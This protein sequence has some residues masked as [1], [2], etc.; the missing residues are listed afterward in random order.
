MEEAENAKQNGNVYNNYTFE[1]EFT[2]EQKGSTLLDI[3]PDVQ[4]ELHAM[5]GGCK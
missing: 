5:K 4:M 3:D 1:I 2:E